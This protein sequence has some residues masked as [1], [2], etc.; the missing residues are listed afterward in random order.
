MNTLYFRLKREVLNTASTELGL[1]L[2]F[3]V[4][5]K[6]LKP[7]ILPTS[8]SVSSGAGVSFT[9]SGYLQVGGNT[10]EVQNSYIYPLD[11]ASEG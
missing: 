6:S 10:P 7:I 5:P 3:F 11:R 1:W 9:I 2:Q 8:E 4:E